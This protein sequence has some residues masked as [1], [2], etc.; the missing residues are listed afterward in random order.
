M[1]KLTEKQLEE[2]YKQGMSHKKITLRSNPIDKGVFIQ[3]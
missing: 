3:P 1:I 2:L